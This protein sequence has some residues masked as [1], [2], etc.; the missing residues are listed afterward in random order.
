MFDSIIS[1]VLNKTLGKYI[2]LNQN[3]LKINLSKKEVILTNLSLQPDALLDFNLPIDIISGSVGKLYVKI[4]DLKTTKISIIIDDVIAYCQPQ[5]R[6][7]YDEEQMKLKL[8]KMKEKEIEEFESMTT[9]TEGDDSIT[10]KI[11]KSMISGLSMVIRNVQFRYDDNGEYIG[12]GINEITLENGQVVIENGTRKEGMCQG[13][14]V[15]SG[16]QTEENSIQKFFQLNKS[17]KTSG[18]EINDNAKKNEINDLKFNS[19]DS[20]VSLDFVVF[21]IDLKERSTN[22]KFDLPNLKMR[23][24]Q[25]QYESFLVVMARI[26]DYSQTIKY[27]GIRPQTNQVIGN[28]KEWWKYAANAIKRQL[29]E[30]ENKKIRKE[31]IEKYEK[32]YS[33]HYIKWR[34]NHKTK[35]YEEVKQLDKLLRLEEVIY[36]RKKILN[37]MIQT[38]KNKNQKLSI[39]EQKI[40]DSIQ[41]SQ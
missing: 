19:Y 2:I 25:E 17:I 24:R 12:I 18:N 33:I 7:T 22:V 9:I 34:K 15:Y 14:K 41:I 35:Y 6:F 11:M 36:L 27:L 28:E 21:A 39:D 31:M 40:L 5:N 3:A 29:E 37:E 20:I 16:K 10:M 30:E 26:S 13:V 38:N 23:L 8:M 4:I 32:E 1:S